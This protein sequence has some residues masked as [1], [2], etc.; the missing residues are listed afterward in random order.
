MAVK[1]IDLICHKFHSIVNWATTY[2]C[3]LDAYL[4][5][6][7]KTIKLKITILGLLFYLCVILMRKCNPYK[8]EKTIHKV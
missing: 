6:G 1:S 8:Q 4:K 3:L 5:G 7:L 2:A